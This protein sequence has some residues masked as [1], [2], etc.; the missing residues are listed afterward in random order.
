MW[1]AVRPWSPCVSACAQRNTRCPKHRGTEGW[2]VSHR[3]SQPEPQ[4]ISLWLHPPQS[5]DCP[6]FLY[7]DR[8][9]DTTEPWD[10]SCKGLTKEQQSP[11]GMSS[12]CACVCP[13][14]MSSACPAQDESFSRQGCRAVKVVPL[15]LFLKTVLAIQGPGWFYFRIVYLF[16]WKIPLIF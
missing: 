14:G 2:P 6:H 3:Q 10:P 8:V 5:V 12:A 9:K 11:T 13:T 4:C 15:P 7:R 16:L 1:S